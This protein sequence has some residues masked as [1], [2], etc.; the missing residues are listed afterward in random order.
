MNPK[1][2]FQI[3]QTILYYS[4]IIIKHLQM[5]RAN[6]K[7]STNLLL[8]RKE[9]LFKHTSTKVVAEATSTTMLIND[10]LNIHYL[11]FY[12]FVC[13]TFRFDFIFNWFCYLLK[14]ILN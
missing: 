13:F 11:L 8:R 14:K 2:T 10:S 1:E 7:Y 6:N 5:Y 12:L 3:K 9:A 4:K